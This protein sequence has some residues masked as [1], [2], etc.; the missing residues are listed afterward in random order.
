MDRFTTTDMVASKPTLQTLQTGESSPPA[1][2]IL[3]AYPKP[4]DTGYV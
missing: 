1:P 2:L 3:P 4:P